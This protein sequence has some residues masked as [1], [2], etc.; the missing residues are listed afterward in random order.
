MHQIDKGGVETAPQMTR[1]IV[2]SPIGVRHILSIT[3]RLWWIISVLKR[4][5][6]SPNNNNN[7]NNNNKHKLVYCHLQEN[8]NSS[9][10]QTKGV[11][12]PLKVLK[13]LKNVFKCQ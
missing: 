11:K 13:C 10:L 9:G 6:C 4:Q 8:Q 7:N 2:G 12:M 5:F 1:G 3:E